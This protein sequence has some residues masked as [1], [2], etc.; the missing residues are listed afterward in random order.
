MISRLYIF[1]KLVW[2]A[3]MELKISHYNE[4]IRLSAIYIYIFIHVML[5][6]FKLAATKL[7]GQHAAMHCSPVT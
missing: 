1:Q 5:N 4:E 2:V 6:Q 3:V 7:L